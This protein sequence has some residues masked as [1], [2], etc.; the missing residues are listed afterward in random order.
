MDYVISRILYERQH[1]VNPQE[2]CLLK[3]RICNVVNRWTYSLH[4]IPKDKLPHWRWASNGNL[5]YRPTSNGIT[6]S[7]KCDLLAIIDSLT[8]VHCKRNPFSFLVCASI[9][10]L[11]DASLHLRMIIIGLRNYS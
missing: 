6:S 10:L 2:L 9:S 1:W 7:S 3:L 4:Q 5:E 11:K 8:Q